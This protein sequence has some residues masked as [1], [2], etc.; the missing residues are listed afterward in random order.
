M[1]PSLNVFDVIVV[2]TGPGGASV[3]RDLTKYG[4]KVLILERGDYEPTQGKFSQM[5]KRGWIPV[6]K[7]PITT[8]G[9]M[10]PRGI[11]TGGTGKT[12]VTIW[13]ANLLRKINHTP[14]VVSRG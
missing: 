11:T 10:V 14:A 8:R 13:L 7:M 9:T 1:T 2:G 12:P 5:L 4:K 6:T 3:A